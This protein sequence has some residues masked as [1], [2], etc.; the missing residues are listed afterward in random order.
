MQRKY[1][2][3][4]DDLNLDDLLPGLGFSYSGEEIE[5]QAISEEEGEG[6][7]EETRPVG[8]TRIRGTTGEDP[9]QLYLRSIGRIKLLSA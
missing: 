1:S 3:A 2:L 9:V 7:P 5:A 4:V 6:D 8:K